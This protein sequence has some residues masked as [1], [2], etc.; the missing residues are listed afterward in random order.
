MK[1]DN[2]QMKVDAELEAAGYPSKDRAKF[3]NRIWHPYLPR[4]VSAVQWLILTEGL[5]VGAWRER[6]GL[7]SNCQLCPTQT[8]ET[9]QHA[10]QECTEIKQVWELFQKTRQVAGLPPSYN[11]WKTISRGLMAD[12]PGPSAE[13]SLRWDTT[14]AF[15]FTMDTPWDILRAQ[16][17][18]AIWRQRV[19]VA[20]KEEH[21]HLGVVL[22]QA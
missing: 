17:L 5:P 12:P 20:F 8:R 21:F 19:E 11:N 22:W 16:I 6:I 9:L 3:F 2:H 13:K 1:Q 4:K 14:S 10:F 15:K 7:P 18:W